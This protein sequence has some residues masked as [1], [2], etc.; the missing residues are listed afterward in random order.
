[1][2]GGALRA[3]LLASLVGLVGE[4]DAG[5][6][7]EQQLHAAGVHCDFVVTDKEPT[8]TKLRVLSRHQQ[9]IRLDF[10]EAF[11][12][13]HSQ[14][15]AERNRMPGNAARQAIQSNRR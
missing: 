14:A 1:M 6:A 12:S 10:E 3:G 11:H 15:I 8:I 5:R 2:R 7:L 13:D 4:D 9:L